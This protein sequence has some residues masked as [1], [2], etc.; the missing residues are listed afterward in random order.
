MRKIGAIMAAAL[1]MAA[2]PA[3]EPAAR[4]AELG[5]LAGQW[6]RDEGGEWTRET[7]AEPRG[8]IM[9]GH[10]LSGTGERA[11]GFEYLMLQPGAGGVP[12]YMA[13]PGGKPAVAFV[14]VAH[15]AASATFEN[16]AHDYPQ[17]IHYVRN[18]DTLTAT[19]S[20]IDGSQPMRWAF[21]RR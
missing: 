6:E 10:S 5:W 16:P 14:L 7:W 1:L 12:T 18:G 4:V 17:R 20:M 15:D 2:S 19:I 8:G 3:P 13:Q 21:A 9:L 11:T